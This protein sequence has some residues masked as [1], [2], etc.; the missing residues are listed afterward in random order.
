MGYQFTATAEDVEASLMR[1]S[2]DVRNTWEGT[3]YF[4]DLK[5]VD[6]ATEEAK[7]AEGNRLSNASFETEVAVNGW[8]NPA[9][10]TLAPYTLQSAEQ[11]KDGNYVS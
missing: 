8:S 11:V 6:V 5:I 1:I 9:G 2:L 10:S 3:M 4:D 7:E